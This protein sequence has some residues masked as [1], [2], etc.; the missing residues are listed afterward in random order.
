MVTRPFRKSH[1]PTPRATAVP[2][3][4]E[5]HVVL[6]TRLIISEAM[7]FFRNQSLILRWNPSI[8]YGRAALVRM[9]S[10]PASRS[11]TNPKVWALASL[12]ALYLS[13]VR[14]RRA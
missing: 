13:T 8:T 6:S 1:E 2:T 11:S 7:R 3:E 4:K 12:T 14:L 5:N 10:L 9:S